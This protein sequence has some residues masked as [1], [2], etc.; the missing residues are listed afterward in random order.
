MPIVKSVDLSASERAALE[1]GLEHGTTASF[2]RRCQM[3]L[4]KS[5]KLPSAEVAQQ[6]GCCEV[7]VNHW[8]KRFQSEG[9]A[10]LHLR[11][12]RGRRAILQTT[13]DLE[14][15]RRA[16]QANRQRVSLA[17]AELEKELGKH[18]STLTLQRFLKKTVA[19]TNACESE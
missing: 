1:H 5:Q 7:V 10:G 9:I 8:L 17:K 14:A 18:F 12:G 3:I 4:L 16:V 13:T 11:K 19:A 15:V 2:R 6:V